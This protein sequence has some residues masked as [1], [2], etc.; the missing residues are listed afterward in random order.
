MMSRRVRSWTSTIAVVMALAVIPAAFVTIATP[1]LS[2]ADVCADVGGD[3]ALPLDIGPCADVLAQEARWLTAITDGDR[4]T[5]DSILRA[6]FRHITSA[7]VLLDRAQEIAAM[8]KEPF[9][10]NAT[11]QIVDIAGDTAVIH[12][13]NTI[14]QAGKVLARERFTDVFVLQN[15]HWMALSA[16]ETAT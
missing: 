2:G 16:Q 3:A 1:A 13:R 8:V 10:M 9:T 6:N 7:G 12:G 14:T 11:E 4:D 15:G 5:V